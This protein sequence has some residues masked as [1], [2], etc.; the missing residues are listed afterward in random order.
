MQT[1]E[2]RN[3]K[4]LLEP[5]E[6][7]IIHGQNISE[8]PAEV[9][10]NPTINS[11]TISLNRTPLRIS[12]Q[13]KNLS[14]T[15]N[16]L[17]ISH[18]R[19]TDFANVFYLRNLN[20][21][22]V[23][24]VQLTNIPNEIENLK[25][26]TFLTLTYTYINALP[27]TFIKLTNLKVLTLN[28]NFFADIPGVVCEL[29]NLISLSITN[30]NISE[31][32]ANLN[33]MV[34]LGEL[35][36]S[37]NRISDISNIVNMYQLSRLWVSHNLIKYIPNE[38]GTLKNLTMLNISNNNIR[39]L[40]DIIGELDSLISLYASSNAI[41]KIG[42]RIASLRHLKEID[43]ENNLISN[44]PEALLNIHKYKLT[45]TD[46]PIMTYY[47]I[48]TKKEEYDKVYDKFD[49]MMSKFKM[50]PETIIN[51]N[52]GYIRDSILHGQNNPYLVHYEEFEGESY[53]II[54]ILKGT[55]LFTAREMH[56][57]NL[58]ESYFH[59]YKL[60]GNPTLDEY[61]KHNFENVMTYFFP[62]PFMTPVVGT[63]YVKMD[64][65]TLTEDIRL[66]CLISPSPMTRGDKDSA[67]INLVNN[68]N[69]PYYKNTATYICQSRDYDLCMS[70]KIIDGL[71]LNG[72]IGIAYQDSMSHPDNQ[73]ILREM[74]YNIDLKKSLLFECS[75]F[76]NAIYDKPKGYNFLE[77]MFKARTYGI[78]EIVLIPYNY[79]KY[80]DAA[81][82]QN[83]YNT[84][85]EMVKQEIDNAPSDHFIFEYID[86]V[87]G[88]DT[89]EVCDNMEDLIKSL[90]RE[91]LISKSLQA[92]PLFSIYNR[93][94]DPSKQYMVIYNESS[95]TMN[96]VSF[97]NA[98]KQGSKC[99]LE[100]AKF[101]NMLEE[102]VNSE[103]WVGGSAEI[104]M[105]PKV[106]PHSKKI[107]PG[108]PTKLEETGPK[109]ETG[110]KKIRTDRIYYNEAANIPI[111]AFKK[112]VKG[113]NKRRTKKK[114]LSNKKR[115]SK[116]R[117]SKRRTK[118][119][120]SSKN[121][122]KK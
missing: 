112:K 121:K 6:T 83:I 61:K 38:I 22:L 36:I 44:V 39:E 73:D 82:Y 65:V 34:S 3:K 79:H 10:N 104:I 51:K 91:N 71:Q 54:S 46:N 48:L 63:D 93:E 86:H 18:S 70:S 19:I 50:Q 12:P 9:Y 13:I 30:N 29:N 7:V 102:N 42:E 105:G 84:F 57:P 40:P 28:D 115:T 64:V 98:Y 59:L 47:P 75:C 111:F 33:K 109:I 26:L 114:R 8:I 15:L 69:K 108:S 88:T 99:A 77:R 81:D 37:N 66:L 116:R 53:P 5:E 21:L 41:K 119:R 92:Y 120:Y 110:P 68:D 103:T 14:P 24:N 2:K 32:P 113:G 35:Y 85:D 90:N 117:T 107:V 80:G 96:D 27:S 17:T 1:V 122:N 72:Y 49:E 62:T 25:K 89:F 55:M 4:R 95:I 56:S 74:I 60:Y 87:D 118:K 94:L 97:P 45:L 58:S 100:I 16:N 31:I 52:N 101:Y 20:K 11:L 78:P 23:T 67:K 76:N 106:E 43:L